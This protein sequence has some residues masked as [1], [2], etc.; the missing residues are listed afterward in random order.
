ML[1]LVIIG[2]IVL[3]VVLLCLTTLRIFL[4]YGRVGEND[5]LVMEITAWRKLFY[6][7]YEIPL[8]KMVNG[9]DG[10]ELSAHV[11]KAG[12]QSFN[13]DKK[14]LTPPKVKRWYENYQVLLHDI[15]DFQPLFKQFLKQIRCDKFEWH[16][17]LGLGDAGATGSL[18]GLA[19]GIKSSIITV[20][21]QYVLLRSIPKL[22]VQPVWNDQVVQTQFRCILHFR[23]YHV[24]VAGF[25]L[26]VKLRKKRDWKILFLTPFRS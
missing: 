5:H 22:S 17:R 2:V 1:A 19:W 7:K 10:V 15:R 3:I 18:T 14:K 20:I 4:T 24:F 25:K 6:Y 21:S 9:D 13:E 12:E 11:E 26:L 23:L 8:L 16:T